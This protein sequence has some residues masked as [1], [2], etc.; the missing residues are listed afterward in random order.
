MTDLIV[1]INLC[2]VLFN[3][4]NLLFSHLPTLRGMSCMH[5]AVMKN[6]LY[7]LKRWN[8][9]DVDLRPDLQNILRHIARYIEF[10]V[11]STYDSDLQRTQNFS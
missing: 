2:L 10:I 11:R 9:L 1:C 3:L 7:I 4:L 8:W 5:A 6:L